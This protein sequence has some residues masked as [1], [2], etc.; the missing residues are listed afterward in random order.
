MK[1]PIAKRR[2]DAKSFLKCLDLV[3]SR[4]KVGQKINVITEKKATFDGGS[5][6]KCKA[7]VIGIYPKFVQ[8]EYD[9]VRKQVCCQE[10]IPWDDVLR[11]NGNL[12][13]DAQNG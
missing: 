6:V 11:W 9:K 5:K 2:D 13:E 12:W 10:S 7:K 4:V 3:K 1:L 8:V